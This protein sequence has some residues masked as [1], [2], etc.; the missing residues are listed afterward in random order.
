MR[1]TPPEQSSSIGATHCSDKLLIRPSNPSDIEDFYELARLAGAGFTS[2][3]ANEA[4]LADR[5]LSSDRAFA[6]GPG[7]FML[8]L[9]DTEKRRI[10]GCAA[11]KPGGPARRD[12]LNFQING[13][14]SN[15]TPTARYADL[16]EVGSLLLHPEYRSGGIGPWL[17]RSRYLL[18]ASDLERFG[19]QI[20]SELRGVVDED[21][22]SPF[23][24]SV[25]APHFGCSFAEA[26]AL[27][28]HGRQAE[29]NALLPTQ[30]IVID[31]LTASARQTMAQPHHA[32]RRALEF[33]QADG[34]R[35]EG[36]IDLLDGGPA[37]VAPTSRIRTIR[38]SFEAPLQSAV[39][40]QELGCNAY[41]AIGRGPRFR[42]LRADVSIGVDRI[43]RGS[44]ATGLDVISEDPMIGRVRLVNDT[45]AIGPSLKPPI[46]AL[47]CSSSIDTMGEQQD[48]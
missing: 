35:F 37:V 2:L 29:L 3:P 47:T 1:A 25:C 9:E 5:L 7:V 46:S 21:D 41:V 13:D 43:V 17:S 42:C 32:G 39:A 20:F 15:L 48:P 11:I 18:I 8:A 6:G 24:E 28:A 45:R 10:V 34:F 26:D 30:P 19:P 36:V 14:H 4:L 16:T 27:S 33:L 38:E 12:F 44:F 22:C 31:D 23:Y 40:D